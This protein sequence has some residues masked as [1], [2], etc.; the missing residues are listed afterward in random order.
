MHT[1]REWLAAVMR[2]RADQVCADATDMSR[3]RVKRRS[4]Q[5]QLGPVNQLIVH[6]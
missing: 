4:S 2:V 1:Q 5:L 3:R 6:T